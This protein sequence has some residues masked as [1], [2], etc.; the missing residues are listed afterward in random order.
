MGLEA[1]RW[2]TD[3]LDGVIRKG[4]SNCHLNRYYNKKTRQLSHKDIINQKELVN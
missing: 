1:V 3:I 2:R 4:I